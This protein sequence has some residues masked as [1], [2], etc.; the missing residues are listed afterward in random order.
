MLANKL[1]SLAAL[2]AVVVGILVLVGWA[3]DIAVLKSILPGW[4][5][6]KA[7]TA[8][9]FI[10]IGVALWLT[11]RYS[12]SDCGLRISEK[13]LRSP[14]SAIL[15]GLAR[16]CGLL[17]GLIGL[18]ALGE[19]I[20]GWNPG[21]DHWLFR[22]PSGTVGTSYPGRMAP[23]AALCFV[24][25]SV[26][27]WFTG[28]SRH[29]RKSTRTRWTVLAPVNLGLLVTIL[30]LAAM[31]SY[32]TPSLGP[33]GWFGLTIMAIHTSVL[34]AML[35][36]AVITISWQQNILP[37][38]LGRNTTVALACGM[39]L[40]VFIGLSINR[41]QFWLVDTNRKIAYSEEVLNNTVNLQI[42]LAEAHAHARGYII[43]GDERFL[44]SYLEAI[45]GYN[46]KM[47]T[48]RQ[49]IVGSPHQQQQASLIET[50]VDLLQRWTQQF[51]DAP[52]TGTTNTA[53]SKIDD[54]GGDLLDNIRITFDQ[55]EN[56]HQQFIRELKQ[57]SESVARFSYI[58]IATGTLASLLI[59][60]TVIFRLNFAVNERQSKEL[61]LQE[62]EEKFRKIT[63]SAQDAIIMIGTDQRISF[64]NAAA[65]R[66]FGYTAAEAIGQYLHALITPASAR[67]GFA[68]AFP[69]FQETGKGPIIGKVRELTALRK[70]GE[71]F[72]AELSVSATQ[73]GGQWHAIGIVRDITE[74]KRAE[75]LIRESE[76]RYRKIFEHAADIIYLLNLDGTFRSISP[77]FEQIT[78]W[79]V[80]EWIGKPFAL[81]VH[82]DDLPAASA[83]FQKALSGESIPSF[84]LRVA[85]KSG[86]YFDAEIIITPFE[87]DMAMGIARDITE[88]TQ[89]EEGLRKS[90]AE[91]RTL[92]EAMPQIVWITR[93]DGGNIYFNQQWMDY[94]GLTLEESLGHGW[95]KPFHPDDQQR[96]WDAWQ[97][98]AATNGIYSIE[99]RLRRADGIYRWWL[100]RG[101]PLLDADDKI[102]KWFGTCTDIHDLKIAELEI[103][104]INLELRESERR[105][106]DLLENVELVSVMRDS[107][108]RI[109]YCN[110]FLLRLTG[111]KYEEIIGR[112]W[113]EIFVP[114][115]IAQQKKKVFTE[116]ILNKPEA[117]HDE[118]EILTRS[119]ERQLI[120]WN[121]SVLRSGY[122]DVTGTASIGEN[123][124]GRKQAE[125]SL[126][127]LSLAV[128]QSP[129]PVI[130]TDL[131]ANIEYV[132][133]AFVKATGYSLAEVVGQ[134]PR[135]LQSGKTPETS[136]NDLWAHLTR[137]EVWKGEFI[138]RR[139]DGSE[140]IESVFVSAV[141][142]AD[143][144]VTNYLA[145]KE[146]ITEHK[147]MGQALRENEARYKRI[148]EG[149]TDYQYTVRIENGRA[150]DTTQS[151]ACATVTGY[152]PEEFAA[153]PHLWFQMIVP[154][155][156]ELVMKHV[157]QVLAGRDIPPI[158]HRIIKKNGETRWISD[159][160]ILFKDASGKL[161]SYDGV[162]K[163][164]TVRMLMEEKLLV[165]KNRLKEAQ[166]IGKLGSLDWDL[167]SNKIELSDETLEL[168]GLDPARKIFEVEEIK[169][170]VHPD[171]VGLAEK[172]LNDA[173]NGSGKHDIEHRIVR[174]D[175]RVIYVHTSAEVFRDANG[176]PLRVLGTA[177]D[178]TEIK[179]AQLALR[180]LNDE[181]EE[182]VVA[183]TQQLLEAQD[184]LVRKE[185][186]AVLGQVAGSVGHELR[187]PLGV[188][189]NAVYF[190]QT[191]LTD[192]D[193][194]T[195][196]YLNIIKDEIAGSERIVS[197]LLDSVRTQ[198]PQSE[199]V[200]VRE[201][202]EKT[203][204]K[205][206][207]PA[208]VTVKL[209]IPATL[210]PLL[211][212]PLQIHQVFRNLISNG[213]EAMPE[214]GVLEISAVADKP[215]GTV[216][217]NV[218]DSGI[219]MTPEQLGKLFQP[220]FTT[221]ARGIGLGLV[222]V[223]NLT[224][225][226]GGSVEVESEL[227]K[228][229]AFS[230]TLPSGGL[231]G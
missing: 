38:S 9:C 110:E 64:W 146:D 106:R 220:L 138:N 171:D 143:G 217:I 37:W 114:P 103:S 12:I 23:E 175:G 49:L 70:G 189:S 53:R 2:L 98:A 82:P 197:D 62:S 122:G 185:K 85:R 41:S 118:S 168:Y 167:T 89:A 77:A 30:A 228:G 102:I 215:D 186:L 128:E 158:E 132:N 127:K 55:I 20:F 116:L 108:E 94:T 136:Y 97:Q 194:T 157:H 76:A 124:T 230:V 21:I 163:D 134:N 183:R 218:R 173:I 180:Q 155:D 40:L 144:R 67:A 65:T 214:G 34:F 3:F 78:G 16:L 140:Y 119:G 184:E 226:N 18:L 160:T 193:E 99:S 224:E 58:T 69:H 142:Q 42:E 13:S 63:E 150:V 14:H 198:P 101:V 216:T 130:I 46:K 164:I 50:N 126:R 36:M 196:E 165:N 105:F 47:S 22:E 147:R 8:A 60:L 187:N 72:T 15:I 120:H 61:A 195:R 68:Q 45:A 205:C 125:E 176:K 6:M 188:M 10:L 92:A 26:A 56:E 223:K 93:A 86:Q 154:Q 107:E 24:L 169:K 80:E 227:G 51:I 117:R 115:E 11:A 111:W 192:A 209:D 177:L 95:N 75:E 91:F 17:A 52:R 148:T 7:N 166:R 219:G 87:G 200:G 129:N 33:Y 1:A 104:R 153:N 25:L 57:E 202:L 112:N 179:V 44:K 100:V 90:E 84:R 66:V 210:S 27:F 5:A 121:N 32:A 172:S 54:H 39:A 225:A 152:T 174:P 213:V 139:K 229:S 182:K 96:A 203:L 79:K 73:F 162:I 211:V 123:I 222:V 199:I 29:I 109:T 207:V 113:V 71:E 201:L 204:C 83:A 212:D 190:L 88:S 4:V 221:K 151:P 159:T 149:L 231:S 137:G 19:Y 178:I 181:L 31:L 170:L 59:F 156:R 131:D 48:L 161:L 191:V 141:R 35:G 206:N 74:R 208:S 81:I 145:I 135:L 43:T 28:D 133:E